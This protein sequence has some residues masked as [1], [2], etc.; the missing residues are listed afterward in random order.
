ML[1]K[2]HPCARSHMHMLARVNLLAPTRMLACVKLLPLTRTLAC[3]F[4]SRINHVRLSMPH[5]TTCCHT[6]PHAATPRPIMPHQ[7]HIK[8]HC[9]TSYHPMPPLTT[10]FHTMPYRA[11]PYHTMPR[12]ATPYHITPHHAGQ[13]P[14]SSTAIC[15]QGPR[16]VMPHH[17][18]CLQGGGQPVPWPWAADDDSCSGTTSGALRT[19]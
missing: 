14:A 6:T 2:P 7:H 8:P 11:K 4:A 13:G 16:H 19:T 12:H 9:D 1:R 5:H 18:I 10:P 15:M 3:L 17:A